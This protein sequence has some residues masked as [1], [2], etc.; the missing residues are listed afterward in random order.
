MPLAL[1]NEVV[2]RLRRLAERRSSRWEERSFVV[3]GPKLLASAMDA[4]AEVQAVYLDAAESTESHRALAARGR[5]SG[6]KVY[7]LQAGVLARVCDTV[8]PQPVAAVV[9]M[10]DR[11]LAEVDPTRTGG[12]LLTVFCVE[13]QDPGN[14]GTVVRSAAASGAG[15]V[16]FSSR[17]VDVYHPKVVRA[18]AGALF[19]VPV[20]TAEVTSEDVLDE[21]GRLGM[22]RLGTIPHGGCDYAD[23]DMTGRT[24]LVLGN[25]S[26]GLMPALTSRVDGFVSIPMSSG[27]ESLNVAM[28]ASILCFEA[29]RQRRTRPAGSSGRS[30]RMGAP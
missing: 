26:H 29:A 23:V 18:S 30:G 1:R 2:Q 17:S 22:R 21:L 4:G 3:E 15:A 24:A 12:G 5:D 19:K 14:A 27:A 6:A 7:E 10:L 16:I 20:V 11:P 8:T 9:S 28:T 25:E 13:M